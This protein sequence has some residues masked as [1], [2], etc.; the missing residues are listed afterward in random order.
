MSPE[1]SAHAETLR[2]D[3]RALIACAERLRA[4]E[5]ELQAGGGAPE[6]LHA[7]VRAHIA[8][9]LVAAADL[10]NAARRLTP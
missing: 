5:A 9:C 1:I 7:S 6:W 2:S 8:A 4:I 10:E 3:A